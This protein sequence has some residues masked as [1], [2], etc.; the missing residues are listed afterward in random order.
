VKGIKLQIGPC[1]VF[2]RIDFRH[3]TNATSNFARIMMQALRRKLLALMDLL[4][5]ATLA[6]DLVGRDIIN[7]R[8]AAL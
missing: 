2:G 4:E 5:S 6:G 8:I 1:L 3:A 7:A